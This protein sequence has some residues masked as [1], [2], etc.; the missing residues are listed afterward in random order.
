VLSSLLQGGN[1]RIFLPAS[2]LDILFEDGE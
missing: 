2:R 1:L